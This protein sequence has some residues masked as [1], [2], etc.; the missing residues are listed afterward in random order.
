VDTLGPLLAV[1]V[2]TADEQDR[3]QVEKLAEAVQEI[4]GKNV[5]LAC[6]DQGYT[7]ESAAEVAEK[8]GVQLEEV[9]KH[10]EVKRGFCCC[11]AAGWW[12]EASLGQPASTVWQGTT[13]YSPKPLPDFTTW[14][15]PFSCSPI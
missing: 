9:V 3:A 13:N 4:T 8:H 11:P 2:T 10:T 6:V 1:H 12:S 14:P 15:S 5:E 7:G